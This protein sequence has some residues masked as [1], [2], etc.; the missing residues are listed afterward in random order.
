MPPQGFVCDICDNDEMK[1]SEDKGS[2]WADAQISISKRITK[3]LEE[4]P[5]YF[6]KQRQGEKKKF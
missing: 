2:S 3:I 4:N 5:D 6:Q 1:D